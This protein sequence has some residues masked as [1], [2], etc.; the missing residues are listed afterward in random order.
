MGAGYLGGFGNTKGSQTR[1]QIFTPVWY[2]G[3]VKVNGVERD[4]SRRVY[5]RNDID[6]NYIDE[7]TGETNLQR[8]LRGNAP[9]GRDKKTVR[10]P[11]YFTKRSR[12]NG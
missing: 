9:Y 5:Q 7:D 1:K 11:S 6:F 10:T 3:T 8:M 4:V 12:S 2:E